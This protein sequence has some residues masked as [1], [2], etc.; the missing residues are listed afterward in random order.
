MLHN[1]NHDNASRILRNC[2]AAMEPGQRPL[3]P[4]FLDEGEPFSS[5]V[6]FMDMD[7]AP[8]T[9]RGRRRT[10]CGDR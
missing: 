5:L 8:L 6:P 9:V 10:R 7:G 1:W 4:D 2:R 3:I